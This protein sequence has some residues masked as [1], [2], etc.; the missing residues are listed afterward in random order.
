MSDLT[1]EMHVH[2]EVDRL[3]RTT[4][5]MTRIRNRHTNVEVGIDLTTPTPDI[6]TGI[7]MG[8]MVEKGTDSPCRW[9]PAEQAYVQKIT[10]E[11]GID[12][13][14]SRGSSKDWSNGNRPRPSTM[15]GTDKD[16]DRMTGIGKDHEQITGTGKYQNQMT[17]IGRAQNLLKA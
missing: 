1:V 12:R 4:K 3:S 14:Q 13:P 7:P 9:I 2:Q 15:T 10:V 11:T 16:Q 6:K 17:E 5:P 8:K